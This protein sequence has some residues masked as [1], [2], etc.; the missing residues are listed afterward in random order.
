MGQVTG[1]G[2]VRASVVTK[3]GSA[4]DGFGE[5]DCRAVCTDSTRNRVG[6]GN[7]ET[8]TTLKDRYVRLAFHLKHAKLYSFWIE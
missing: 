7:N 6:W 1:N 5:E 4:I 8:L 3:D 2:H